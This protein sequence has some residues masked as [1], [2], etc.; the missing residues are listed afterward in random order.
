VRSS[1]LL[2][3]LMEA[4]P[5]QGLSSLAEIT[6]D[7]LWAE[8][9]RQRHLPVLLECEYSY[10]YEGEPAEPVFGV[11]REVV[12]RKT[13]L[14]KTA[15]LGDGTLMQ[16][17]S[18]GPD[19]DLARLAETREIRR[20]LA[21]G[22]LFVEW[23]NQ[24]K[25]VTLKGPVFTTN[26]ETLSARAHED[27]F[28]LLTGYAPASFLWKLGAVREQPLDRREIVADMGFRMTVGANRR[29]AV[30]RDERR[31]SVEFD[32]D[33]G[34][35]VGSRD[36]HTDGRPAVSLRVASF[37]E[38]LR[39]FWVPAPADIVI[40]GAAP[41]GRDV[42]VSARLLGARTTAA[43]I[44][45]PAVRPMPGSLFYQP[46]N[47]SLCQTV[48]GGLD[49][50]ESQ[51]IRLRKESTQRGLTERLAQDWVKTL[52]LCAC[53]FGAAGLVCTVRRSL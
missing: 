38:V 50:L 41:R 40:R 29:R 1:L 49:F 5:A 16:D 23:P 15:Y 36:L 31:G 21:S 45:P 9:E 34:W 18:T 8:I 19:A 17:W 43:G 12:V 14:R 6:R 53:G 4:L 2:L 3:L 25:H 39:D 44:S 42:L 52:L 10:T 35:A 11:D 22:S 47:Q 27:P 51:A 13:I 33:H 37:H 48:P 7:K 28:F 20:Y 46:D 32:A 26:H 24:R 30:F